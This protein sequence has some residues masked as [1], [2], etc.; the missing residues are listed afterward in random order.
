MSREREPPLT[1]HCSPFTPYKIPQKNKQK[2]FYFLLTEKNVTCNL[3][4]WIY[5]NLRLI[6]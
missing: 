3:Y 6:K 4:L 5:V 1:V 2:N